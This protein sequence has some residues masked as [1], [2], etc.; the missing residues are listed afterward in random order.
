MFLTTNAI[1][2]TR[3]SHHSTIA[4]MLNN[5]VWAIFLIAFMSVVAAVSV[6]L[7]IIGV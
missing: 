6:G 4:Q 7:L 3:H 5:T 1:C 2:E